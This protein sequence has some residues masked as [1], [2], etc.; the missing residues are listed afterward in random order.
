MINIEEMV[1][2]PTWRSL[3]IDLVIRNKLDPWDI[4]IE[5]L[6]RNYINKVRKMRL[7]DFDIPGSII[8]ACSILLKF[9]SIMLS[10]EEDDY[11]IEDLPPPNVD[12]V[13]RPKRRRP[14][15]LEDVI[16]IVEKAFKTYKEK[17]R[18][19]VKKPTIEYVDFNYDFFEEDISTKIRIREIFDKIKKNADESGLVRFSTI[20]GN[21]PI[22][23]LISILFLVNEEVIDIFQE[24]VF[25]EI[26]IKILEGEYE[27][28]QKDN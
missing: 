19:I 27:R 21:E 23:S 1:K 11:K 12:I 3:L 18:T 4:D 6:V 24:Q 13:V 7:M 8:L 2:R 15:T 9:Q 17:E 22:L 16:N 20:M 25:G 26:T 28:L 10:Y 5:V 14:I